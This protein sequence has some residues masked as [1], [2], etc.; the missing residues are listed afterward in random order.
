M[1]LGLELERR[2]NGKREHEQRKECKGGNSGNIG[3]I[4]NSGNSVKRKY[5]EGAKVGVEGRGCGHVLDHRIMLL[6][7]GWVGALG[8][9]MDQGGYSEHPL[10]RY[11]NQSCAQS[12]AWWS[13]HKYQLYCLESCSRYFSQVFHGSA[14]LG[15]DSWAASSQAFF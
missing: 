5:D 13:V 14:M 10:D 11:W 7:P 2:N 6:C 3:N 1:S 9:T 8:I 4:G 15:V 12:R